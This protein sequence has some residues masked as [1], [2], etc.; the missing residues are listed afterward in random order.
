MLAGMM[1]RPRATSERTNSGVICRLP[2][3]SA[4][5]VRPE[6]RIARSI[7][8]NLVAALCELRAST[9]SAVR[10]RRFR[11][12]GPVFANRN[13]LHFGGDDALA[14]VPELRDGMTGASAERLRRAGG[15][16][17]PK[18]SRRPGWRDM[19]AWFSERYRC[20]RLR[21]RGLRTRRRPLARGS[22]RAQGGIPWVESP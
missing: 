15:A 2:D 21:P 11:H 20:L 1:A 12:R 9:V 17:A 6:W 16:P 19:L 8:G 5:L 10:D 7:A 18:C 22:I 4:E 13:K 14:R 3:A